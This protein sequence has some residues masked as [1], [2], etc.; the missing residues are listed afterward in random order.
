VA[1][2]GLEIQPVDAL[3]VGNLLQRGRLEGG[4]VLQGMQ[5]DALEQVAQFTDENYTSMIEEWR[6]ATSQALGLPI[7]RSLK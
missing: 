5:G 4:L 2:L 1:I 6:V 3:E 7:P